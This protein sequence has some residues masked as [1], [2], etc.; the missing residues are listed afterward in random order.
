M[1]R[2]MKRFLALMMAFAVAMTTVLTSDVTTAYAA[3]SSKTVKSVTLKIG[4]KNV[5]KKTTTMYVKD[6]ATVKVTV[7]PS[8]AKKSVTFK[9]NK[10][11][12]A[13]V[14]SKGKITAK[15]AGTAKVTVTVK[16]KDNKSK[17][18][19]VNVKVQNRPVKSVKL[20]AT[21]ISL[22]KGESKTLKATVSPSNATVKTVKW[23]SNKTSVATVNSK[24]KVTAKAAGTAVITAKSGSKS[25]KCTVVVTAD[26]PDDPVDPVDP[27]VKV[28]GITINRTELEL[29]VNAEASLTATV[30]PENATNKSVTWHSANTD[31]ATVDVNGK[32]KGIK[33]GTT[34]V[35]A[36]TADGGF[37]A[38]CNVTVKDS[39]D[40]NASAVSIRIA[41]SL[42]DY[43]NT[44]LTGTNADVKCLVTNASGTPLGNTSV[45]LEIEPQFGNSRNVFGITGD[46]NNYVSAK[47]T[48]DADGYASFTIGE[49]GG[50]TYT[51]TDLIYQSYK[52]TATVT[53]SNVRS[54]S[55]LSFA[56][57][58]TGDIEVLNN[59][60]ITLNDIEPGENAALWNGIGKTFSNDGA[61]NEE[62]VSSQK[63]T[64]FDDEGNRTDDHRVY[65]TAAPYIV[66][67]ARNSQTVIDKYYSEDFKKESTPYSVYNTEENENTTTWIKQ[68]P[69]GLEHA[70]L[71][72]SKITLS[73]YT[74][75]QIKTYDSLT[76]ACI[77]TYI[78]DETNMKSDE[79][80]YQIPVQEDTPVDVEVSLISEG[81]VNDDSNDG[82]VI[83]HIEGLYKTELFTQAERIELENTVTWSDSKTYYSEYIQ[84]TY[85][86]AS[87]YIKDAQYL[88][89]KYTY[90]YECPNFPNT[91]DAV[92]RVTD[93][94]AKVVAYFLYPTENQWKN[95][96]GTIYPTNTDVKD[97][98]IRNNAGYQNKNDISRPGKYNGA[99]KASE[100]EVT[101]TVGTWE[102][103]GNV[104]VVDSLK[105]GRTNLKATIS[106]PGVTSE[107][108][109]PTNGSELYTS[110]QWAPIPEIERDEKGD[111]FYAIAT[112]YITVKAQLYDMN[113]NKVTTKDKKVTFKV[114]GEEIK[115]NELESLGANK[116]VTIQK[117]DK[118]SNEQGQA[119]VQFRSTDDKGFVYHL[120]AECEG[121][122]VRLLVGPE[123]I[124]TK[125]ANLYWVK[126][127]LS[128][129]DKVAFSRETGD[130]VTEV[131]STTSSTLNGDTVVKS[132][133]SEGKLVNNIDSRKVGNNWIFGYELVGNIDYNN[134]VSRNK[135]KDISNVKIMLNKSEDSVMTMTT[136]NQPNGAAKCYTE[137]TGSE[138]I[139][140]S[141]GNNSFTQG[142]ENAGDVV[143]TIVDEFDEVIRDEE[144]NE[145]LYKNV[146]ESTP[147]IDAS[148]SLNVSW[149]HSGKNVNVVYPDGNVL[150]V[151]EDYTA[152]IQVID[153]FG[154][155]IQN[156]PVT[157]S[158]TGVNATDGNVEAKTDSNGLVMVSLPKP[159][160]SASAVNKG[161]TITAVV[162]GVSY[163]GNP[164]V[165]RDTDDTYF[166]LM[167]A[168]LDAA[169]PESPEI[170]LTFS[171]S[172]NSNLLKT[173]MFNVES[174]MEGV[175]NYAI[176]SVSIGSSNNV[177][178]LK[179]KPES[180]NIVNDTGKV[181][182]NVIDYVEKGITY[183][184]ADIHGR[185]LTNDLYKSASF[186]PKTTYTIEA[187]KSEDNKTITITIKD[188]NGRVIT[189]LGNELVKD[190]KVY[191]STVGIID[192]NTT[193][194]IF[195][196][197]DNRT[198][199]VTPIASD[200]TIYFYYCG[201]T[202][203]ATVRAQASN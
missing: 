149:E 105:S 130:V 132:I 6:T 113:G 28:T 157:Y 142:V 181:T 170:R 63:V 178:I 197:K 185:R 104:V 159:E 136:E 141:I 121:Y 75:L 42:S 168:R 196:E 83:D 139:V 133:N 96:D 158:I 166:G 150:N 41:N 26:D 61:Q 138:T 36:V 57:I 155:P 145:I 99:V 186:T 183:K 118:V 152:Y 86:K 128:F 5:T 164:T 195:M 174:T 184:L 94:N 43:A 23:S 108:L 4:T 54:E 47:I 124:E 201:A 73:K 100:E 72:F 52:L 10:T 171:G 199:K 153:D 180:K 95:Q 55:T 13:T 24:G 85:E 70:T 91:G 93:E 98:T 38:K 80:G 198:V 140:G 194:L 117:K 110:V 68:V 49:R 129:T 115:E 134:T 71:V 106:I 111:D 16:G 84:M 120:T 39:T 51:S 67:P 160:D 156:E 64:T 34:T 137:K 66:L 11:S 146:G 172:V 74:T 131:K 182:V 144:G 29:A 33:A 173:G 60:D 127:G 31:I 126:L 163:A 191:S 119:T 81:Q 200:T 45:T 32:V 48:T 147:V 44:V 65:L 101:Q 187:D 203:S 189:D 3:S 202:C 92:I 40:T 161:T 20:S 59:R 25:A 27:S 176:D 87:E 35:E 53:G 56:C 90:A 2:N 122:E 169:N 18:T 102:Q 114:N 69:A 175:N 143:F 15:K 112:Q 107:Q 19:Y 30:S 7:N 190:M 78:M 14:S 116:E 50:Y 22:K 37:T 8:T 12:V 21:K 167:G 165:Y 58:D 103:K 135:V 193:G 76:G 1:K 177:V 62:Y 17:S 162:D 123:E 192:N 179:L 148:L 188:S 151:H 97:M 82:F 125:L 109:N 89:P 77:K 79:F 46:N 9:S 154:N 88:S